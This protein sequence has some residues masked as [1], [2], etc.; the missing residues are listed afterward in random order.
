MAVL[1]GGR[2]NLPSPCVCYAKDPMWNRVK[3]AN[4]LI[5][6]HITN[7][8]RYKYCNR[9]QKGQKVSIK[10]SHETLKKQLKLKLQQQYVSQWKAWEL[11]Q[12]KFLW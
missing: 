12:V 7:L 2:Q 10:I 1:Q 3:C 9:K 5:S 11:K 4:K 6:D 8:D